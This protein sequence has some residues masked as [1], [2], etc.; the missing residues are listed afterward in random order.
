MLRCLS[1]RDFVIVERLELEF[2]GG[3]GALTG[4]TGAGKSILIDALALALGGRADAAAVREGCAK[5]EVSANFS[6]AGLPEVGKWLR[7][8]D[9]SDDGDLLLRRVVDAQGRSRGYVNGC[10]A[11]AG[12]MRE[13][14][15]LLVDICGQHAHQALMRGDAQLELLD[16]HAGLSEEARQTAMAYKAWKQALKDFEAAREKESELA[17]E[18][19]RLE[20]QIGE[21]SGLRPCAGEWE[22][23]EQEQGRLAHASSLIEAA[24]FGL[25]ELSEGDDSCER[26]I[27]Q[28]ASRLSGL[29]QYDASMGE[30]LDL[31]RSALAELGEAASALR[32]CSG[33]VE[34]DPKRQQEA[35]RRMEELMGMARKR[36]CAPQDLPGHLEGLRSKLEALDAAADEGLLEESAA[37]AKEGYFALAQALS[38]KRKVA[39]LEMG[40]AVSAMMAQLALGQGKFEVALLPCEAGSAHG[41]EQAEFRVSGLA[42]QE[43]RPLAKVAS[44]G[45]LSRISLAIR[46]LT[47]RSSCVPTLVFDEVDVGIGGGVAEIVGRLLGSLG[48]ERQV[49]CVTHLPQVAARADW[50]WRVSKQK[51]NGRVSSSIVPLEG[52][53]RVEEVSRML[54]GVE[55]TPITRSHAAELLSGKAGPG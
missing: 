39:A 16:A 53:E 49:L 26:R 40:K 42:G 15:E 18:R 55:I 7:D 48:E 35:E 47:A 2:S 37:R 29:A 52:Q 10:S 51:A 43:S 54:G 11:T 25:S 4:E 36:R 33:R 20:W 22:A 38:A 32:R 46:V 14:G 13:V 17:S 31:A 27:A 34:A 41:L 8:N 45:E 28:V 5:A 3:F 12:Q 30:A 50:H 24:A 1:I 9:F 23:L 21:L 44:G 6:A 19:E